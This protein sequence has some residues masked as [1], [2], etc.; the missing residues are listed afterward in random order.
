MEVLLST[1]KI[2]T[3]LWVTRVRNRVYN[4]KI[5]ET[6]VYPE[7]H[8]KGY[9]LLV[10]LYDSINLLGTNPNLSYEIQQAPRALF[11]EP[12]PSMWRFQR[13]CQDGYKK[14]RRFTSFHERAIWIGDDE[15]SLRIVHHP[16]SS[17]II[18]TC[19]DLIFAKKMS[20]II[21]HTHTTYFSYHKAV[22]VSSDEMIQ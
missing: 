21:C 3:V 16:S 8:S 17:F 14:E 10:S 18:M 22:L 5:M 15:R 13:R 20:K 1:R 11:R 7:S 6:F 2:S 9:R 4:M 12:S 19:I